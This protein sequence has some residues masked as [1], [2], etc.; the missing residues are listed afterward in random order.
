MKELIFLISILFGSNET[1][2]N[3]F[4]NSQPDPAEENQQD[5]PTDPSD[6]ENSLS[7]VFSYNLCES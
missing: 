6:N 5:S 7:K 3:T 4:I 2:T 1:M